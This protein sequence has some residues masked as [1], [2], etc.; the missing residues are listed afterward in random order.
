MGGGRYRITRLLGEGAS[1][2]VYLARDTRLDRDVA[3]AEIKS[4]MLD[5][6]GRARLQRE[7]QAMAQLGDHPGIVTVHD[8]LDEGGRLYIISQYMPGGDLSRHLA[9][10]PDRRLPPDEAC[11]IALQLTSALEHAHGRRLIHRDLKPSNI[12]LASDGSAKLG[13]FGLAFTVDRTRL[14]QEG[15]MVGTA[16]YMPPEQA[17][18]Q[19]PDHRS[20]LYAL[21]ATLYEM[22]AGRP[23]FV[24]DDPIAIV[25][26]H[27]Q[28]RPVAP[29]LLGAD[30]PPPLERLILALLEKD[31]GAR[32]QSATLV[33]PESRGITQ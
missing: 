10:R 29:R 27:I 15:M 31:P 2:K 5:E 20:D 3:L 25:T 12:W 23:P 28:T 16:A 11:A 8:V 22:V 14:T 9:S 32:P 1:K 26:Q 21:G 19:L 7:T 30:V 17:V 13:D 24:G 33:R 6:T 4:V 18:G